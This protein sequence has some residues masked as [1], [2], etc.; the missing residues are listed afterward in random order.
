MINFFYNLVNERKSIKKIINHNNK[1]LNIR[2]NENRSDIFLM[3]FHGWQC[4]HL[5]YSYVASIFSKKKCRIVA[6]ENYKIFQEKSSFL[7]KI[8]R[9]LGILLSMKYFGVFKSIGVSKF[10]FPQF[11]F[12]TKLKAEQISTNFLKLNP[13]LEKLEN[14]V[15]NGV[16]IGDLIYDSFLKKYSYHT[17]DFKSEK[18]QSFFEHTICLFLFWDNYFKKNNVKGIIVSH[19][20][21]TS[22]IPIRIASKKNLPSLVFSRNILVNLQSYIS[23]KKKINATDIHTNFYKERFKYLDEI[24][25]EKIKAKGKE[26]VK[27]YV[28]GKK[29]YYY[30]KQSSFRRT[31]QVIRIKKSKKIKVVIF[32]HD[33]T[34]SPH[35]YGN[36]FFPDFVEWFKFLSESIKKTDYDW[37]IKIHPMGSSSTNKKVIKFAKDNNINVL[38][39]NFSNKMLAKSNIDYA[40]TVFGTISS[41]LAFYNIKVINGSKNTPYSKFNFCVNPKN[42]NHYKKLILNLNK[43]KYKTSLEELYYFHYF[44]YLDEEKNNFFL[45]IKENVFEFKKERQIIYTPEIYDLWIKN[46]KY[47]QHLDIL[48]KYEKFIFSKKYSINMIDKKNDF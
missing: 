4:I 36:H 6:F 22:G 21:Y 44:K 3:E 5:L 26:I 15:L 25:K 30:L 18:F 7:E 32:P 35:I 34:D 28:L 17:I 14:F 27:N 42:K 48:S 24:E 8:R 9:Q 31:N 41:E 43:K 2:K 1:Y 40:L 29:K 45:N 37:Y 39:K 10:I 46:F 11:D 19:S 20:V 13:N 16:W 38:P 47:D 33:F 12:K 23:F